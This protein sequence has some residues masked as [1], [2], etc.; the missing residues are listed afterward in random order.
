[1]QDILDLDRGDSRALERGK[2]HPAQRIAQRQTE[3]ALKRFRNEDGLTPSVAA[4]LDLEAGGLLQFLPVL[5][6]DSHVFP[7][8]IGPSPSQMLGA[9]A[10]ANRGMARPPSRTGIK[11]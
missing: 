10:D 1:M 8:G 4:G 6:V 7:L 11:A 9:L 2:Q 3:A 5:H